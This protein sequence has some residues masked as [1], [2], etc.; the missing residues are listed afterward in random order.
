[1]SGISAMCWSKGHSRRPHEMVPA[2]LEFTICWT[3]EVERCSYVI[4][5]YLFIFSKSKLLSQRW[6]ELEQDRVGW[7][8]FSER[9][10]I[11]PVFIAGFWPRR[12]KRWKIMLR[13][14]L[15]AFSRT[16]CCTRLKVTNKRM[17]FSSKESSIKAPGWFWG[18]GQDEE[19]LMYGVPRS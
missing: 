12:G 9:K 1:M 6:R 19:S 11:F 7:G 8:H 18:L 15:S 17:Y 10:H 5:I 3:K 4:A 2:L 14:S 16:L 13:R